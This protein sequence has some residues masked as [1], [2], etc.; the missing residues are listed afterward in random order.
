[1][2]TLPGGTL[3]SL[4]GLQASYEEGHQVTHHR[5][6]HAQTHGRERRPTSL[7]QQWERDEERTT[8]DDQPDEVARKRGQGLWILSI[9]VHPDKGQHA[10]CAAFLQAVE[11]GGPSPIPASELFEVQRWLLNAVNK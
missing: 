6:G 8:W 11:A 1:M 5:A 4:E 9:V 2:I 3:P 7:D 10:C